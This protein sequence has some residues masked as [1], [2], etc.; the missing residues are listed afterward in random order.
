MHHKSRG[1]CLCFF[2]HFWICTNCDL[3]IICI[4]VQLYHNIN[5]LIRVPSSLHYSINENYYKAYVFVVHF[6][7]KHMYL[8][9]I[10]FFWE[11]SHL[12]CSFNT[13]SQRVHPIIAVLKQTLM[14][15]GGSAD[16]IF[17]LMLNTGNRQF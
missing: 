17:Y 9:C 1:L 13:D 11:P 16:M 5:P 14:C 2:L 15:F 10:F 6:F 4:F 7:Y 12:L 8:W 3:F